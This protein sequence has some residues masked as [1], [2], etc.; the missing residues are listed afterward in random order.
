MPGEAPTAPHAS[1]P[2]SNTVAKANVEDVDTGPQFN[3]LLTFDLGSANLTEQARA[4]AQVFASFMNSSAAAHT[5][6][7]IDGHTDA[8]GTREHNLTL[9]ER[10]AAAAKDYLVSLGVDPS[11]LETA[12][13][14]FDRL[15][16]PD[17]PYA[18]DNRRVVAVKIGG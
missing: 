6:F 12:G 11:R 10:R 7:E 1:H 9:S 8:M 14:G 16:R 18:R 4:N 17:A 3:M 13:F 5:R 15:A 2:S